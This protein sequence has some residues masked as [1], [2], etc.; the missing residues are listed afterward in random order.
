MSPNTVAF[1]K[2]LD[3]SR[4]TITAKSQYKRGEVLLPLN[5]GLCSFSLVTGTGGI[6]I[7]RTYV[8]TS[9]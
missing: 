7:S 5:R 1:P 2:L 6:N 9:W 3:S 4:I 8:Y